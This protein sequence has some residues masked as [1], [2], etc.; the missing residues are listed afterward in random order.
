MGPLVFL[1][2]G[3]VLGGKQTFKNRGHLGPRLMSYMHPKKAI[4]L[5]TCY[6]DLIQSIT[7]SQVVIGHLN[8]SVSERFPH[9]G[10]PAAL[11]LLRC[12]GATAIATT[13]ATQTITA[14][15]TCDSTSYADH[16]E[17]GKPGRCWWR[18]WSFWWALW[19][20][21]VK[22]VLIWKFWWHRA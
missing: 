20:R 18:W 8:V 11:R 2:F 21:D 4:Q 14:A 9:I 10:T 12:V 16:T 6:I 15:V 3:L 5:Y 17:I 13:E 22:R 19:N 7:D 1:N